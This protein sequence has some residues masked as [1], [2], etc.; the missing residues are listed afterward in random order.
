MWHS[1]TWFRQCWTDSWSW[2]SFPT[3]TV[4][5][6]YDCICLVL[7]H[8]KQS[9]YCTRLCCKRPVKISTPRLKKQRDK[10]NYRRDRGWRVCKV[11]STGKYFSDS[12]LLLITLSSDLTPKQYKN[13]HQKSYN[14]TVL[15][16]PSEWASTWL[17]VR[18]EFV[19]EIVNRSIKSWKQADHHN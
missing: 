5:W 6:F 17:H 1:G 18:K 2:G 14:C 12:E 8:R 10:R 9:W 11:L 13:A 4:V 3:L 15:Q 19:T 7:S 16:S